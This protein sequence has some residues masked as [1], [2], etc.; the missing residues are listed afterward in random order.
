M[1]SNLKLHGSVVPHSESACR[2]FP[3]ICTTHRTSRS[4]P[5]S[6]SVCTALRVCLHCIPS[7]SALH[8][9]SVGTVLRVD[10]HHPP[11]RSALHSES[12]CSALRVDLLCTPSRS[13][14][15]SESIC[16]ISLR[17]GLHCTLS[18]PSLLP[19]M[20]YEHAC[21]VRRPPTHAYPAAPLWRGH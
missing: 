8:S 17:V 13:A 10:L 9:D 18:C 21:P 16:T 11:S 7:R 2:R 4:A 3:S 15:Y 6:V 5:H 1:H 12:I 20:T 14:E 19:R